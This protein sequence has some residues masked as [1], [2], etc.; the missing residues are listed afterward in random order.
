MEEKSPEDNGVNSLN[1]QA[2][3][4]L[5]IELPEVMKRKQD[6]YQAMIKDEEMIREEN[7]KLS[8]RIQAVNTI[9]LAKE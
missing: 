1:A 5:L 7:E 6:D 8:K 2:K 9:V 3:M 4:K